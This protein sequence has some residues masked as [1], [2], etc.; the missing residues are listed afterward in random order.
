[1][2][3]QSMIVLATVNF[4][5]AI[6][7]MS[8][9]PSL[10]FY[11]LQLGGTKEQYGLIMSAFSFASFASK[12]VYGLWVDKCDNQF[13][14]PYIASLVMAILGGFF[15]FVASWFEDN[16]SGDE[17]TI[18]T[19]SARIGIAMILLGRVLGGFGAGNAAIGYA[20]LALT[21]PFE[22]QTQ[23][24]SMLSMTRIVGM[25]LGPAVNILL[26]KIDTTWS[27]FGHT[28]QVTP[29]NSVGI[30]LALANALVLLVVL[31]F[32]KEPSEHDIPKVVAEGG[33][34]KNHHLTKSERTTVWHALFCLEITLPIFI[35]FVVNSC[36]QLVETALA[37]AA[38]D[39]LGYGPIETSAILSASTV[40]IFISMIFVMVMSK[41]INDMIMVAIGA[42][43]WIVGGT[44]MYFGW[45]R[46]VPVWHFVVPIMIAVCGFPF[47]AASNR[48]TYSKSVASK[49]EL[50]SMQASMQAVLS[51]AASIAGF[52]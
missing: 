13:R 33:G 45:A 51:M 50:E 16:T 47:I 34:E 26:G 19:N 1:M 24:N 36:F 44:A 11:V 37:P 10:V 42:I 12:P 28:L 40:I 27:I 30:L 7:Y 9:A 20:Y 23:T 8:V 4:I 14:M 2:I 32:L 18:T 6:S 52:V 46:D 48:S 49:P 25:A 38:A 17:E 41:Y 35:I 31:I 5:D 43:F 21:V 3:L 29:L 22:K 39:S 15:Y